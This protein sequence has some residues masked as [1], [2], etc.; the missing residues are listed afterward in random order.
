MPVMSPD[1]PPSWTTYVC[2]D[3]ADKTVA[4]VES[5]RGTV[6]AP[7]MA[8]D[9]LGRLAVL[10]DPSGAVRLRSAPNPVG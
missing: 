3:D 9:D 4:L 8:V 10:A 1:Q 6:I 5:T 7:P 2:S